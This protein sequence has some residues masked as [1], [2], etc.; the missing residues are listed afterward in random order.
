MS[1]LDLAYPD[2]AY[3]DS[4]KP[5]L[6][7]SGWVRS[8]QALSHLVQLCP[9]SLDLLASAAVLCQELL[10]ADLPRFGHSAFDQE[11][12]RR[13]LCCSASYPALPPN[14]PTTTE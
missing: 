11:R 1:R 10:S 14:S 5:D 9:D 4:E 12:N 7:K 6:E 8:G 3:S 2:L 13:G